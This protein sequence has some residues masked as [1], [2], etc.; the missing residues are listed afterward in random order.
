MESAMITITDTHVTIMV[1]NMDRA[2]NFYL[3]IGM[4]LK[5]RWGDHY[6]MVTAPGITIGLH[7]STGK[8]SSGT[9]SVGFAITDLAEARSVLKNHQVDFKESNDK[10]GIYLHFTDRDGTQL[11][12]VKPQW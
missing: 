5:D 6:A 7:P 8:T 1:K 10:S 12:Y 11:Y 9:V 4:S 2:I 3:S